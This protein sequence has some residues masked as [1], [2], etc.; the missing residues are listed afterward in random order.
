MKPRPQSLP[1]RPSEA[2]RASPGSERIRLLVFGGH[3]K[4]KVVISKDEPSVYYGK[5]G[6]IRTSFNLPER[7]IE[8][9]ELLV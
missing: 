2:C 1:A 8:N 5:Q 6:V 9:R 4:L 3:K 7:L